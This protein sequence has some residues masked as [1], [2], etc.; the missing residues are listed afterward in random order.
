MVIGQRRTG[1]SQP[2]QLGSELPNPVRQVDD[3]RGRCTP[4]GLG[5]KHRR[6]MADGIAVF[7]H[8]EHQPHGNQRRRIPRP[9]LQSH[10]S[11]AGRSLIGTTLTASCSRRRVHWASGTEPVLWT[12]SKICG[13]LALQGI[14]DQGEHQ[15]AV[16]DGNIQRLQPGELQHSVWHGFDLPR[17]GRMEFHECAAW[18]TGPSVQHT[19]GEITALNANFAPRQIQFALKL[20]F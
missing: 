15:D 17:T 4:Q 9:D 16:P 7:D 2:L 13:H 6:F 20:L 1:R 5:G 3:G 14:C 12:V 11:R 19:P 18:I 8:P 10:I